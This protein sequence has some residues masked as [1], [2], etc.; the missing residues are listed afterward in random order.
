MVAQITSNDV[1]ACL[2][3]EGYTE[4]TARLFIKTWRETPSVRQAYQ[5]FEHFTLWAIT[6]EK[7]FGAK[8]I[9]ERVRW[10]TEIER[11]EEFKVNNDWTS[12]FV[13]IFDLRYPDFSDYFEKRSVRGL[14]RAA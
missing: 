9:M 6:K 2:I 7:S 4:E 1:Y 8:A 11:D 5:H 14:R 10:E 3:G 12:I 13:R